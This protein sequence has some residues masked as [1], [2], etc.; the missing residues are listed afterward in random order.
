MHM[1][2][3]YF[4]C[5]RGLNIHINS[6]LK[7]AQKQVTAPDEETIQTDE[8]VRFKWGTENAENV[9]ETINISMRSLCTGRKIYLYNHQGKP[10]HCLS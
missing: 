8:E 4:T 7:N 2:R 9:W 1:L 10:G 6:C 5:K 3:K